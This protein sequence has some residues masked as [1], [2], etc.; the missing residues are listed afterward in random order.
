MAL[1]NI[2]DVIFLGCKTQFILFF[3]MRNNL[4][5]EVSVLFILLFVINN[6]KYS[7]SYIYISYSE[8]WEKPYGD[9]KTC[10]HFFFINKNRDATG[11]SSTMHWVKN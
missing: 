3:D 2:M 6:A 10:D 1:I 7:N 5:I 8:Y 11:Q 9:M 4:Y